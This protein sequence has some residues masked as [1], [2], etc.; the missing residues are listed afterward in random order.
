MASPEPQ[1]I[2]VVGGGIRGSMFAAAVRQNPAARLEAVC[3]P[4]PTRRERIASDLDVATFGDLASMIDSTPELTALIIATPDFAHREV[5]LAGIA[6]GLDLMIEKPLATTRPDARA[7]VAAAQAAG[8]KIMVGFEN[9]WNPRFA[10]VRRQLAAHPAPVVN[11]VINLN[12]TRY[13]PTRMLSWAARSS[14]GWFLMPHSLDLAMWLSGATPISVFARGRRGA[15]A[16]AGVD[17]WDALTA[18]FTMSDDSLLVLNSQ[19]VLPETTPAVFD[20]RYEIHTEAASYHFDISHDSVTRYDASGASWLQFGVTE[21][22]GRLRGIPIDMVD[23][24]IASLGGSPLDLPDGPH[25]ELITTAIE[26]VHDAAES[27]TPQAIAPT[28]S[29]LP[30]L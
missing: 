5:A 6:A 19:W 8:T 2:G 14:P 16:A 23:D 20:F 26:A 3:E 11:Q 27:G 13:V 29:T 10:E 21:H 18:S 22:Q 17:T 15:L 30:T 1:Q 25:G 7:I 28:R 4:D 24:F 12:D 9:R